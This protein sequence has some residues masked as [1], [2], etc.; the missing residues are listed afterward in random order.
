VSTGRSG[1]ATRKH[2]PGLG[3]LS[4]GAD[5]VRVDS[6]QLVVWMS[7]WQAFT[8]ELGSEDWRQGPAY[9][10]AKGETNS[11]SA[12]EWNPVALGSESTAGDAVAEV[13]ESRVNSQSFGRGGL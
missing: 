12:C 3:F 8:N 1:A 13:D 10:V 6:E 5:D 9:V 2:A 7:R 4:G 11:T